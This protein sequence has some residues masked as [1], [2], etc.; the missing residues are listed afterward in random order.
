MLKSNTHANN[1][2]V[3]V[4]SKSSSQQSDLFA[5]T[6][7]WLHITLSVNI[8]FLIINYINRA[9]PLYLNFLTTIIAIGF[10]FL[11]YSKHRKHINAIFYIFY[12][13]WISFY[14]TISSYDSLMMTYFIVLLSLSI[15]LF[16]N[17]SSRIKMALVTVLAFIAVLLIKPH[18]PNL[19]E[20]DSFYRSLIHFSVCSAVIFFAIWKYAS[21]AE[22]ESVKKDNLIKEVKEKNIELERFA[23]ITSHDLKQPVRNIVS[24]TDLLE[25]N[26]SRGNDVDKN[27]EYLSFIKSSSVNLETLIDDILRFSKLGTDDFYNG[28]VNLNSTVQNILTVLNIYLNS[29]NAIIEVDKLPSIRGNEIY[30]TLLLQNLIEN[31]IK[32]NQSETP[33]VNIKYKENQSSHIIIVTD[34]GLG[35]E[36]KYFDL[37]LQPFKRLHNNKVY[38]GSGLGLS[39]CKKIVDLFNGHI[40]ISS[41]EGKGSEFKVYLPK[42]NTIIEAK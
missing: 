5:F 17:P 38:Q 24:F 32:Y 39:I 27:L 3:Q 33:K 36:E 6:K 25:R 40:E 21:I 13:L 22:S 12:V 28:N 41:T 23:Y 1:S 7:P 8:L 20:Y 2:T 30:F 37:I 15:T 19:V 11:Y 4:E 14:V 35:I 18:V 26:V 9:F 10:Y 16:D 31:G 34:N 29:Q 42:E